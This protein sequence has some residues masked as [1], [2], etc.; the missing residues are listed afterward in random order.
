VHDH[1]RPLFAFVLV[2]V[3]CSFV[4]TTTMRTQPLLGVD[5]PWSQASATRSGPGNAATNAEPASSDRQVRSVPAAGSS[6]ALTSKELGGWL[7]VPQL[8]FPRVRV[9]QVL[10]AD[11]EADITSVEEAV[12]AAVTPEATVV[13]ADG[14][15]QVPTTSAPPSHGMSVVETFTGPLETDP[16]PATEA[17]TPTP[18]PTATPGPVDPSTPPETTPTAEPS[19]P[20]TSVEPPPVS[21]RT[22]PGGPAE[23]APSAQTPSAE[24][25]PAP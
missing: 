9:E 3:I 22:D 14:P 5:V 4:V 1:K 12:A 17:P 15:I 2:A 21:E 10:A 11:R 6:L 7:T 19:E 24:A 18:E 25:T 8:R 20:T 23:P 13:A 16:P